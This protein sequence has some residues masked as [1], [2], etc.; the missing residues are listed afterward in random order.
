MINIKA[1]NTILYCKQWAEVVS[2]YKY[3]LKLDVNTTKEW[4]V[5]FKV[6]E[7]SYLSIADESR[8]SI[9]SSG[10][11][12]LTITFEVEDIEATHVF[13]TEAG[14]RPRLI[15]NHAWGASVIHIYD[16]QGNRLEFWRNK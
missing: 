9:K 14:C 10:G 2:F 4:F 3:K 15:K 5:E 16:P 6:T 7:H 8:T 13:L 1:T 12:G 11:Q